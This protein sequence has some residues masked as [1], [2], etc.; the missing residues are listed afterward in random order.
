MDVFS[1]FESEARSYCRRFNATF[2]KAKGSYIYG[3]AGKRYLDFLSCAGALNYGHNPAG[4]KAAL[5]AYLA[6]DGIQGALD[7]HTE[8]KRAFIEA[9][10]R[11]ILSRAAWATKCSSPARP[12]PASSSR[13]SSWRA[14]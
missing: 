2:D 6:D 9:F 8:A 5:L 4:L 1:E 7:L 11:H 3:N 10:T 13:R 14:R 12:E